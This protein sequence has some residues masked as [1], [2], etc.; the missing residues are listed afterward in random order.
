MSRLVNH[1]K[2][3]RM[4]ALLLTLTLAAVAAPALGEV[5]L[6]GRE[7]FRGRS[8]TINDEARNLERAGFA[9]RASS[10]VVRG[11]S[12]EFC[13]ERGFRGRCVMLAPGRYP[14][15]A[16]MGMNDAVASLRRVAAPPP[17]SAEITLFEREGFRG[18]SL[19]VHEPVRNL[20]RENFG[21]RASSAIVR[22]GRFEICDRRGFEGR[23]MVLR[24]GQYPSLA[25]MGMDDAVTSVRPVTRQTRIEERRFAPPPPVAYDYR[26]RHDERLFEADVVAVRAVYGRPEQ[27]CWVERDAVVG[28]EANVGGAIAGAII[29]GILGHQVGSGRGNDA[30][31]AAGAVAGAAIGSNYGGTTFSRDVQ[32]CSR[33]RVSGPPEYWD[34]TYR[35]RGVD[36]FVQMTRPPGRTITVNADGE[37]RAAS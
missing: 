31:T 35:F 24:P 15:L 23:C 26:R 2:E 10:A 11:S 12:Y 9:D 30:A 29:G 1:T 34:V 22:G 6:Y 32:R 13:D 33:D 16:A 4:K 18:Q 36:R 21:D 17:A 19:S 7:D 14:T 5:T 27:R 8:I 3:V 28:G 20:R 37:P 25:A